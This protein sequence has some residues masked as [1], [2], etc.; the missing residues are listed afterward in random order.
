M[1]IFFKKSDKTGV[2]QSDVKVQ[3][4]PAGD[5]LAMD[6]Q[7]SDQ[8]K[9]LNMP[10]RLPMLILPRLSEK[11]NALV[12]LNKY[13]FKVGLNTNKIEIR[14]AVEKSYGVNVASVN[15]VRM[16]GKPRRYGRFEGKTSGFKKAIVTLTPDSKKI[17]VIESS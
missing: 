15:I 1:A 12:G 5:K 8:S 7:T 14:K 10:T 2:Q 17:D 3:N 6:K 11:A 16:K 4:T 9:A 13:V